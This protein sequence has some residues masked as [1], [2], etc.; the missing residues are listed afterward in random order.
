MSATIEYVIA[1]RWDK[2]LVGSLW[3][4]P[5]WFQLIWNRP[6]GVFMEMGSDWILSF[7]DNPNTPTVVKTGDWFALE[8]KEDGVQLITAS[9]FDSWN[10]D[11]SDHLRAVFNSAY[12]EDRHVGRTVQKIICFEIKGKEL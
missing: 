11:L 9:D 10:A 8:R 6:N 7:L 3:H 1:F 12:I 4:T 5:N 2:K